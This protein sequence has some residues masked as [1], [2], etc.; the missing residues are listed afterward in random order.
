M[1]VATKIELS[2][3]DLEKLLHV[4]DKSYFYFQDSLQKNVKPMMSDSKKI[5][6]HKLRKRAG[7]NTGI[8][9]RSLRVVDSSQLRT[10]YFCYQVVA[11]KPHYRLTHLLENGHKMVPNKHFYRPIAK[12]KAYPHIIFGQDYVDENAMKKIK[13]AI[14]ESFGKGEEK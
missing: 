6:G 12:T 7:V 14:N 3:Q 4:L 5:V 9:K 10:G 2:K 13:E 1:I 11:K 8:Y